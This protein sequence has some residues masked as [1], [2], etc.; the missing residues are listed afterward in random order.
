MK[1]RIHDNWLRLR[2]N[3]PEID[4]LRKT[5]SCGHSL[6]SG[7]GSHLTY[8]LETSPQFAGMDAH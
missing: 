5:S 1:L 4:Q 3:R 2:L 8:I 6:R 7:S